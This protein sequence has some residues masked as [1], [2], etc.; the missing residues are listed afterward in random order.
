MRRLSE[1]NGIRV[2]AYSGTTGILLAFDIQPDKRKNLL[3]FA[4]SREILSGPYTGR[5]GWLQGILDF[6]GTTKAQGELI[7]TNVA[8]IQKFRWSDYAVYPNTGYCYTVQPVYSSSSTPVTAANRSLYLEAGPRVEIA[9]QSFDG[10][11]AIIFNRAVASSQAFSRRFPDLD[12]EIETARAARALSTKALP[13]RALNWLSRGLVEKI[14][15]FLAEAKD[16]EWAI[17]LA[18]YEYHLPCL[19]DAM[20]A[21]GKRGVKLRV[22]Y[23]AKP[24]DPATLDNEKLLNNPPLSNATLYAR[25]TNKIMHNKFAILSKKNQSGKYTPVAVLAGSTNWTENGCYRQANVVHISRTPSIL[26]NYVNLFETL[27]ATR[28]DRGATKRWINKNNAIPTAPERFAGFSP[29]SNLA[30]IKS[31]EE[32]ISSARRDVI[33]STAFK[34]RQE[35]EDALLGKPNDSILRLGVQNTS[36]SEITGI[37]RDRSAHFTATALLPGGLEGWLKETTARQKGNIRVHTKAI[38]IDVTSDSPMVISGSHNF[39][40]SAS[41]SNDENYI[42][43][44]RDLDVA[45]VYLC[46]IMRIYDHYRFRFSAKERKKA[47]EPDDPPS[48]VGDSTWTDPYF[49]PQSLKEYD[50]LWFSGR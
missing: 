12:A 1:L 31:V 46:E 44:R 43:I 14:K 19:H 45:D 30:D 18:I 49:A 11:D 38:V 36:S 24:N 4:I 27:I 34:L 3:G 20:V 32:L 21:A 28:T 50:R 41:G 7:A 2:K 48:L 47:G 15:S 6:P 17:D 33:F 10:E 29:R 39:S 37:H 22:V 42:I 26:E 40:T 5:I 16:A 13:Q 25:L 35:I 23:H 9:T 8:P